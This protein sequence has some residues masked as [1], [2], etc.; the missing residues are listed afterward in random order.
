MGAASRTVELLAAQ[1]DSSTASR[2][3]TAVLVRLRDRRLHPGSTTRRGAR[4][5]GRTRTSPRRRPATAGDTLASTPPDAGAPWSRSPTRT[6]ASSS[7]STRLRMSKARRPR[8]LRRPARRRHV[9]RVDHA[10]REAVLPARADE[11]GVL[12]KLKKLREQHESGPADLRRPDGRR[13]ARPLAGAHR[14]EAGAAAHAGVLQRPG[15]GA[16]HA[17]AREAPAGPAAA[18]AHRDGVGV[19]RPGAGAEH[20]PALPPGARPGARRRLAPRADRDAA[21]ARMDAP[22]A[23]R[24][25]RRRSPRPRPARC[26]PRPP[27]TGWPPGGPSRCPSGCGRARRSA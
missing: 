3:A 14:A 9:A 16:H 17:G 26:S 21:D 24:R 19:D 5:P 13:V 11:E 15:P 8:R 1:H 23:R 12:E 10:R 25:S 22:T 4:G 18:G 20:G 6:R 27:G 7:A 2:L